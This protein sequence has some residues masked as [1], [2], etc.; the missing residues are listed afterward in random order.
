[1][2]R[3]DDCSGRLNV[4]FTY[5]PSRVS[6]WNR[7]KYAIIRALYGEYRP[8]AGISYVWTTREP[9]GTTAWSAYTDR[10]RMIVARS[11]AAELGRWV[12]ESRNVLDDYRTAFH[13]EPPP[14]VGVAIMT[15]T[16]NTGEK[17]TACRGDIR[18]LGAKP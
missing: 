9:P 5:D 6:L 18:F 10:V 7:V 4:A 17:A 2:K 12:S 14:I 13:E 15:D 3:R 8:H 11:G 16:D 1:V